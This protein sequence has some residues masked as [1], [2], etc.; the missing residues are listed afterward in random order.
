M[1]TPRWTWDP[2][3]VHTRTCI[4]IVDMERSYQGDIGRIR[5]EEYPTLDG[6]PS[7][8]TVCGDMLANRFKASRISTMRAL[9][10]TP[11]PSSIGS[12]KT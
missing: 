11:S 7:L 12:P 6:G 4:D 9:L 10:Y 3:S 1:G 2:S 8:R 5:R